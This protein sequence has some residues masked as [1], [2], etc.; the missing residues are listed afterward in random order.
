MTLKQCIFTQNDCY[1]KGTKM[2]GGKPTGIVVHSTGANNKTLKRYVQPAPNDANYSAIIADLGTN[3]YGNHWNQSAVKMGRS[4]CVHAF[5]GVNAAGKVETYQTLPFDICCW[6]VGSGH[7][8]S[9]NYN[10]Q[11]RV[12]FEMCEDGLNDPVYFNAVMKEAQEFCAYLCKTY[13]F[14][15]DKIS[16]HY[17]SYQQGYGGNHGDPHNWLKPFG[18]TMDWFRAEVQKLLDSKP[19]VVVPNTTATGDTMYYVQT[20][21]YASKCNADA[22]LAKVKAAGFDA[23]LKI[24][25]G[26][27]KVQVGAYRVRA[28]AEAT[29]VK[30]KS[31]GFSTYITTTGGS[32]V[33]ATSPTVSVET[34]K[35]GDKVKCKAGVKT[36]SNGTKMASWVTTAV[37]Y[38][39]AIESGGKIYLVSTEP[40][41]K[42]YTGRVNAA[43]VQKI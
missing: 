18:K 31:A 11:A 27:Y 29:A 40:T 16:S 41:K 24:S 3:T 26:L 15:V 28:N 21:A 25:G 20:G 6:G 34:I 37:L 32:V 42:V 12:Q 17:E 23:I 36:F 2:T 5:I 9:Y 30:L 33:G 8:G 19:A 13:G 39:R 43:D 7:K 38:V 10:P 35:V 1:K 4:V 22:Q 14:G